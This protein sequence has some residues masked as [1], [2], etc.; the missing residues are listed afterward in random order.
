M[1]SVLLVDDSSTVLMSQGDVLMKAG[2]RVEKS[3]DGVDALGKLKGGLK[4]ALMITD[5]NMPK[6]GGIE[7]IKE[8]RKLAGFRFMPIL[9]MTTESQLQKRDEA[10]ANGATGWLVKP[11]PAADLLRTIK[12]VLPGA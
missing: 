8:V 3:V 7:L 12:Q 5:I 9:V 10:R 6:M 1:T 4:P 2:Y 11:V